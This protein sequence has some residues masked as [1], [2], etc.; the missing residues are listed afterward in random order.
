MKSLRGY[1]AHAHM[2]VQKNLAEFAER[3]V[4]GVQSASGYAEGR[5]LNSSWRG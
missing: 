4:V 3:A 5:P 1:V 2:Q